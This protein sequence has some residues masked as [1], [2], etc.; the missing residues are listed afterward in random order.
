MVIYLLLVNI[1]LILCFLLYQVFFRKLTFF[2]WNRFYL[3]GAVTISFLMPLLQVVD[4][5]M[6]KEVYEPLVMMDLAD[7]E[8]IV[9]GYD[10]VQDKTLSLSTW[11]WMLYG[12]GVAVMF[13]WLCWRFYS[14]SLLFKRELDAYQSFSFFQRILIGK[15]VSNPELI[16]SHERVHVQHGHSY[17][18]LLLELVRMFNWFNPVCYFYLREM[19]LQHECIAD[20]QCAID[21]TYYAEL[22]VANAM[23]VSPETL[24]HAF[25]NHSFLKK[26]IMML[27]KNKSHNVNRMRYALVIPTLLFLSGVALAFNSSMKDVI[28]DGI[29]SMDEL[30]WRSTSEISDE[31]GLTTVVQDT[32][33]KVFTAVEVMPEP[34]GGMKAFREWVAKNYQIPNEAIVGASEKATVKISFIVEKDGSLSSFKTMK[35]I[36]YGVADEL[37]NV[38]K[39]SDKWLPG[40]QGSQPVRVRYL[41]PL[42]VDF[43]Q[44]TNQITPKEKEEKPLVKSDQEGAQPARITLRGNTEPTQE[45]KDRVFTATEVAPEPAGGMTTF[46]KWVADNYQYPQEAIDAGVKGQIVVAFVIETDGSLSDIK[47]VKDVG[48]GTGKAVVELLKKAKPWNPAIQNGR[49]VRC[50]YQMP[51]SINLE[52]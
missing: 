40:I 35:D 7:I 31:I 1:S 21:K 4:L 19:K 33:D 22:L 9:I 14:V 45:E 47:V 38:L 15:N 27:F 18:I 39:K 20:E 2:Q 8:P 23:R 5:S 34:K 44:G 30:D 29:E 26:R 43:M 10:A 6:H 46:R 48:F 51:L 49:K 50:L 41:L 42:N 11:F 36:G 37:I 32:T 52:S 24:T 12:S 13:L 25:S 3:L 28:V 17:D 16:R